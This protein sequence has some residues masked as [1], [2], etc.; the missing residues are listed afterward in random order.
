MDR[1]L[2][3]PKAR[4]LLPCL[5]SWLGWRDLALLQ[6]HARNEANGRSSHFVKGNA[7]RFRWWVSR[8][9][10]MVATTSINSQLTSD[11]DLTLA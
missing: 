11:I 9:L 10:Q 6:A 7:P 4:L 2:V 1:Q 8:G 3:G 5:H